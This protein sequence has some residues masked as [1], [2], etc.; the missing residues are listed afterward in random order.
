MTTRSKS[1]TGCW[2]CRVRKIKCDERRPEC[3]RCKTTGIE[4]QG[5]AHRLT[6]LDGLDKRQTYVMG[7]R[8]MARSVIPGS[9]VSLLSTSEL[10]AQV[11]RLDSMTGGQLGPFSVFPVS[12]PPHITH[13]DA[14]V[15]H[16]DRPPRGLEQEARAP[17]QP[18]GSYHDD[19]AE[20]MVSMQQSTYLTVGA[21]QSLQHAQESSSSPVDIG[22]WYTTASVLGD[23]APDRTCQEET[24]LISPSLSTS[25]PPLEIY[26]EAS[27]IT[28]LRARDSSEGAAI[29]CM[30]TREDDGV[31]SIQ[32]EGSDSC[33]RL[34]RLFRHIDTL[35]R[36]G[37]HARLLHHWAMRFSDDLMPIPGKDNPYRTL[38]MPLCLEGL[39][40]SSEV[41]NGS[42]ALFHAVCA[43]S[44]FHM[45]HLGGTGSSK[46]IALRHHSLSLIHL[47][48]ALSTTDPEQYVSILATICMSIV[49]EGI[50]GPSKKW[51]CHFE[52]GIEWLRRIPGHFWYQ[53][54]QAVVVYQLFLGLLVVALTQSTALT[55]MTSILNIKSD[56]FRQR[57]CL[58]SLYGISWPVFQAMTEAAEGLGGTDTQNSLE[59]LELELY[60]TLPSEEEELMTNGNEGKQLLFH[61]KSAFHY[62]AL[63]YLKK[64]LYKEETC[65][66]EMDDL[67]ERLLNH[68]E[69]IDSVATRSQPLIWPLAMGACEARSQEHRDRFSA[70]FTSP[71]R[72]QLKIFG[73]VYNSVEA[74]WAKRQQDLGLRS[75]SWRD[76]I[77][78]TSEH[79]VMLL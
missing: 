60:L 46:D 36:P 74:M 77:H 64:T 55:S 62:G 45:V 52:G 38:F 37:T 20:A 66:S 61:H 51:R 30:A 27:H 58:S 1:F 44:A 75:I 68:V 24:A 49:V 57:F 13:I 29:S 11:D 10:Q 76:V 78:E 4:C 16:S 25:L 19:L 39:T 41:S 17:L 7:N 70:W 50:V 65:D 67:V 22:E 28:G 2:T 59:R 35:Q 21:L 43:A 12:Q 6:W 63:I 47:R 8:R 73:M 9:T 15:S 14:T 56:T 54:Q 40:S 79:D 42:I 5:Y 33:E 34:P 71:R 3:R 48:H 53:T 26:R 72:L 31:A 18:N 23:G 69:M 32:I